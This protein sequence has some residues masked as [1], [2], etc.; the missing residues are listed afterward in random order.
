MRYQLYPLI[1]D[2]I[3]RSFNGK[4]K[5]TFTEEL[6]QQLIERAF[7]HRQHEDFN[8]IYSKF[9]TA[10]DENMWM[11]NGCVCVFPESQRL[12]NQVYNSKIEL[13][14]NIG[15]LDGFGSVMFAMPAGYTIDGVSIPSVLISWHNSHS[16]RVSSHGVIAMKANLES[17]SQASMFMSMDH[18][19]DEHG[20][21]ISISFA[22]HSGVV[23]QRGA[24][25][26]YPRYS[27]TTALSDFEIIVNSSSVSD[28]NRHYKAKYGDLS[29]SKTLKDQCI[30]T[31]LVAKL[32]IYLRVDGALTPGFPD[33]SG[34]LQVPRVVGTLNR[35]QLC[36][37]QQK[38]A[39]SLEN[40]YR[41]MHIRQLKH[42][43]YYQGEWKDK[44]IGSRFVIV[45]PSIIN[46]DVTPVT[47]IETADTSS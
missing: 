10:C 15:L 21:V 34:K 17:F 35:Y 43:K 31:K 24:P 11:D 13:N 25:A 14:G 19:A 36:S 26:L 28:V 41:S 22:D 18:N 45:A 46:S 27:N 20:A 33:H 1:L 23:K 4:K 16:S 30:I 12:L 42:P 3:N 6:F 5:T 2:E 38:A 7:K 32:L 44:P 29:S 8:T 9:S 47:A 40:H 39:S 37:T